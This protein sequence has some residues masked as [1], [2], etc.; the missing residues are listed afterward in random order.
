M[1]FFENLRN[2]TF[3]IKKRLCH[4]V[5]ITTLTKDLFNNTYFIRIWKYYFHHTLKILSIQYK[6][7]T[8]P[9]CLTLRIL[10][11]LHTSPNRTTLPKLNIITKCRLV[12]SSMFRPG[13]MPH[14]WMRLELELNCYLWASVMSSERNGILWERACTL[15]IHSGMFCLL[16]DE[17]VCPS[18]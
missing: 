9:F 12:K 14:K 4:E 13:F 15:R 17:M 10:K 5:K 2:I 8:S 11:I 1:R 3:H 6:K 7:N 18:C 16:R